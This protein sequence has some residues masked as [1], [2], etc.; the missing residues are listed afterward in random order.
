MLGRSE[1]GTAPES[2]MV[3]RGCLKALVEIMALR[4]ASSAS[5]PKQAT[6]PV[7]AISTPS[8]GSALSRRWKENCGAL[9][10]TRS[11]IGLAHSA[12]SST[13]WPRKT[14][15]A[16]SIKS[17]PT[18]LE[19]KGKLRDARRFVSITLRLPSA[20]R[21]NCVFCGPEIWSSP[22]MRRTMPSARACT[23]SGRPEGKTWLA[24]PLCTPA[25][26]MCTATAQLTRRPF[27]A[28]ASTSTSRAP[29]MN[30]LITTGCSAEM[31]LAS[32][33]NASSSLRDLATF[34]AAPLST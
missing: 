15:V 13:S 12:L 16:V 32:A 24:S 1:A 2:S 5:R 4:K 11:V 25:F 3:E 18:T 10:Q 17:T 14:R 27:C 6:S 19:M 28:T 20:S 9:T 7:L 33:R 22:A 21:R 23:S 34:M 30:L 26:S 31:S 29:S 8:T